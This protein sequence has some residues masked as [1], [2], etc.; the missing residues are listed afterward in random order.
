MQQTCELFG[1]LLVGEV[2]TLRGD[3]AFE[4]IRIR[5]LG[6]HRAVMVCLDREETAP[7]QRLMRL[8]HH[9]TR[10]SHVADRIATAFDAKAEGL[11]RI[12]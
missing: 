4:R 6:E 12:M 11:H 5:P 1:S 2:P 10:V 9:D 7:A 8:G 3:A